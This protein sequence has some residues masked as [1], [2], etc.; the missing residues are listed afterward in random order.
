M[1]TTSHT[2]KPTAMAEWVILLSALTSTQDRGG[3]T[4][5]LNDP[6]PFTSGSWQQ[7]AEAAAACSY[8]PVLAE[9]RAYAESQAETWHVWAGTDRT[10]KPKTKTTERTT[11]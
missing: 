8:C 10:T 2:V 1:S 3:S 7:R 11:R 5:C 6:E 9:C 4:P